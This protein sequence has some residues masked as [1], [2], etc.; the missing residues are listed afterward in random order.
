MYMV[1]YNTRWWWITLIIILHAKFLASVHKLVFKY[2]NY[3]YVRRRYVVHLWSLEFLFHDY[4]V[5]QYKYFYNIM[6]FLIKHG[7]FN[8]GYWNTHI[9]KTNLRFP[10]SP[11]FD[12]GPNRD[13]SDIGKNGVSGIPIDIGQTWDS[14][15]LKFRY[16]T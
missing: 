2:L 3:L 6:S 8:W 9:Y 1:Y 16:W 11:S 10:E 4:F 5:F 12:I 15:I 14:V 7:H 13:I